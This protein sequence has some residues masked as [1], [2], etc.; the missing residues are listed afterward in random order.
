HRLAPIACAV[1]S[2]VAGAEE[3]TVRTRVVDYPRAC[4]D[5]GLPSRAVGGRLREMH[6][7]SAAHRIEDLLRTAREVDDRQVSLIVAGISRV[8][9]M[10]DVQITR[11]PCD[12]R[13]GERRGS[14]LGVS[15]ERGQLRPAAGLDLGPVTDLVLV[16]VAVQTIAVDILTIR[17]NR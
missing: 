3:D 16:H 11:S 13:R 4:P 5:G 9:A 17:I 1:V 2:A 15:L 10:R 7:L 14:F 6:G 8:T 12:G